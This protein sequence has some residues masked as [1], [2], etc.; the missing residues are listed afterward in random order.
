MQMNAEHCGDR[1]VGRREEGSRGC[2]RYFMIGADK[3]EGLPNA[4]E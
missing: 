1:R 4:S 3:A 2:S